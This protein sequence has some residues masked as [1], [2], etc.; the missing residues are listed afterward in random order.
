MT[1]PDSGKQYPSSTI[2]VFCFILRE[3]EVLLVERAFPPYQG[4]RT[5]PGGHKG[6]G[7]EITTACLR[8][9][10]EETG[11]TL[12]DCHFAGFMQVH[13]EGR[14]GPEA[15]CLYYAAKEF[16]GEL[17]PS[18]EGNLAWTKIADIY[19]DKGTHPALRALLPHIASGNY[20]F[21]AEA[22]VDDEGKGEYAVTGPGVRG[23][24]VAGRHE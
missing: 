18:P 21:T 2:I 7:E 24:S 16:S 9:M 1:Q 20:P 6:Y 4:M 22:Y 23:K 17:T 8:E 14:V 3:D 12:L 10:H 11:L 15:L 13:R 19:K 5:I